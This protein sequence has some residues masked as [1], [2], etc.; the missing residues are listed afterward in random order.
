MLN[1]NESYSNAIYYV[2]LKH[3]VCYHKMSS[4]GSS[5]GALRLP[6][7]LAEALGEALA[8]PDAAEPYKYQ[9]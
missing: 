5:A 9:C 8:E 2:R 1:Y 4:A 3:S 6:A 7:A